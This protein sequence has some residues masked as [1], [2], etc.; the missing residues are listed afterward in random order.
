MLFEGKWAKIRYFASLI[1]SLYFSNSYE[2]SRKFMKTMGCSPCFS[3]KNA[4]FES[5]I[6][7][8]IGVKM[9]LKRPKPLVIVH[10]K[11]PGALEIKTKPISREKVQKTL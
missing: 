7:K 11:Y 1:N 6:K 8:F 3:P 4:S 9:V 2:K 5:F 10:A